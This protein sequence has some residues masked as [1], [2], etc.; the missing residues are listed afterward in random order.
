ME[1]FHRFYYINEDSK[2]S[3]WYIYNL[4]KNYIKDKAFLKQ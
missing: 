4:I 2:G 3:E 1:T